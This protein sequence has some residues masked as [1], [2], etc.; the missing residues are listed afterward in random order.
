MKNTLV[1]FGGSGNLA[2][3][4]LYP[5]LLSLED[6]NILKDNFKILAIASSDISTE[7]FRKRVYDKIKDSKYDSQLISKFCNRIEY[8]S[9][10]F[11][12]PSDYENLHE[13]LKSYDRLYHTNGNRIFYLAT[14]PN[15]FKTIAENLSKFNLIDQKL[16]RQKIVIEKPFGNDFK[17]AKSLNDNL[18]KYIDEEHIYRIDHYLG[19]DMIAN[20]LYLRFSNPIF[21]GV[22]NKDF[23]DNIQIVASEDIGIK[24]RGRY[25]DESGVLK[26]MIQNHLLQILST[27]TM[28]MPE[29]FEAKCIQKKKV[30]IFKNLRIYTKDEISQYL[31]TGQYLGNEDLGYKRYTEE[32]GIH[33][34]S[35]TPTF[36]A[37]ELYIDNDT[38]RDVPIYLKSGKRLHDKHVYITIEFKKNHQAENMLNKHFKSNIL[39]I[40][41][42]PE[43]GISIKFNLKK[44]HIEDEISSVE[45]DF[46]KSCLI[47]YLAPDAYEKIFTALFNDDKL[48][49]TSWE[50]LIYTWRFIDPIVEFSKSYSYDLLYFYKAGTNGPLAAETLLSKNQKHWWPY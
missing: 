21:N 11:T 31:V 33:F 50:E 37:L 29:D 38:W 1:I 2:Y 49:F 14:S 45:M 8:L 3:L 41:I 44:P 40:K 28:D 42:Q 47:D 32:D 6:K 12:N 18:L 4:K 23:I 25:Y 35:K 7:E 22:W 24:K 26:D 48:L 5:A 39:Q 19:K 17:S 10:S 27:V 43:E 16:G 9:L 13:I 36:A 30:E 34:N 46:C 15:F 20:I